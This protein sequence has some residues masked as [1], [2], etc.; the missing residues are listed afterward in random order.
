[1]SSKEGKEDRSWGVNGIGRE[2][3]KG[4]PLQIFKAAEG[5]FRVAYFAFMTELLV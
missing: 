4:A 1:M 3:L 5:K 2:G